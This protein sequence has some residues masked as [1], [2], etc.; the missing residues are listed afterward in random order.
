MILEK[1]SPIEEFADFELDTPDAVN[2]TIFSGPDAKLGG[3]SSTKIRLR[4]GRRPTVCNLRA[5]YELLGQSYPPNYALFKEYDVWMLSFK[6]HLWND[7]AFKSVRQLGCQVQYPESDMISIV[8]HLP[9][10]SF[11]RLIDGKL[12]VSADFSATG[13]AKVPEVGGSVAGA[14]AE[15][16]A[17]LHAAV[18]AGAGINLSFSVMTANVIATGTADIAGEWSIRRADQPL[19]GEQAFVHTLLVPKDQKVL[20]LQLRA[21]ATVD[22]LYF[23][24]A[25]VNTDWLKINVPLDNGST[26]GTAVDTAPATGAS[27]GQEAPRA[28]GP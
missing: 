11:V 10:S 9:E 17:D 16:S 5:L 6:V 4:I 3:E 14:T 18:S 26:V 13:E 24:P 12:S 2:Q 8:S 25:R 19:L 7:S 15:L 20:K 1:S 21:Y 23:V 28:V 22:T 27:N